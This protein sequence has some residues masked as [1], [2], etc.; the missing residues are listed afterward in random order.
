MARVRRLDEELDGVRQHRHGEAHPHR[1]VARAAVEAVQADARVVPRR[2][3]GDCARSGEDRPRA[4]DAFD[5]VLDRPRVR[6]WGEDAAGAR[7]VGRDL[8]K[9]GG[10]QH[11]ALQDEAL[12]RRGLVPLP[13]LDDLSR[14]GFQ[15]PGI[16]RFGLFGR[17][18][19][20]E[21]RP[22]AREVRGALVAE[23]VGGVDGDIAGEP[24]AQVGHDD[25][26]VLRLQIRTLPE[27]AGAVVQ[28]HAAF[29]VESERLLLD[30][31]ER[32]EVRSAG[33]A[34][35]QH[36]QEVQRHAQRPSRL[37]HR[38]GG[39]VVAL[40]RGV[41]FRIHPTVRRDT[42]FAVDAIQRR[43]IGSMPV[44]AELVEG[45]ARPE[46]ND[47]AVEFAVARA[48]AVE[49]DLRLRLPRPD[50]GVRGLE[51]GGEVVRRAVPVARAAR[52]VGFVPDAPDADVA[53]I[54]IHHRA[55]EVRPVG[56]IPRR[57]GVVGPDV[58][59]EARV[60]RLGRSPAR[61]A[62]EADRWLEAGLAAFI[63]EVVERLPPELAFGRLQLRPG[64]VEAREA[65]AGEFRD[66]HLGV[67]HGADT[68]GGT[69]DV[70][71]QRRRRRAISVARTD[72]GERMPFGLEQGDLVVLR[73]VVVFVR[74]H[75]VARR[76]SRG[77]D[78]GVV[79]RGLRDEVP[80][81]ACERRGVDGLEVDFPTFGIEDAPRDL[82][83]AL[84]QFP[85]G[86]EDDGVAE[87]EPVEGLRTAHPRTRAVGIG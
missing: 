51:H 48:G 41:P 22:C 44:Q 10:M 62:V 70:V 85:L 18:P 16:E 79:A 2:V 5:G 86:L 14:Q 43:R 35:I 17:G 31:V 75:D 29:G 66:P 33:G 87:R 84:R 46:L 65:G 77:E 81:A 69:G 68:S 54:T 12:R 4:E 26:V 47:P 19:E 59:E 30:E 40:Q 32:F 52:K 55:D 24:A 57:M 21:Q 61:R 71:A 53:A 38:V 72:D 67:A 80:A 73:A 49:P 36:S 76:R 56:E 11:L 1:R 74:E 50:R 78:N 45:P 83:G 82:R 6:T 25:G 3:R 42:V 7:P 9:I 13:V 58:D 63:D 39:R 28:R 20:D 37:A 15:Q 23:G 64:D 27:D 34:E 60:V 8:G